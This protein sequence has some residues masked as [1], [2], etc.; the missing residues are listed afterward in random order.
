MTRHTISFHFR[1]LISRLPADRPSVRHSL[2]LFLIAF[3]LTAGPAAFG[4][5]L[6]G[7]VTDAATGQGVPFASIGVQGRPA[8]TQA[9]ENGHYR[10]SISRPADTLLVSA[11]GYRSAQ[12]AVTAPIL[13]I[14]LAP[15]PSVLGEVVVR[16]GENP[17]FRILRAVHQRRNTNDF[18]R[19][20]GYEYESYNQ[21]SIRMTDLDERFSRRRP[22][23][24]LLES[25]RAENGGRLPS[26]LPVFISESVSRIYSRRNPARRKEEILK[27]NINSIGITD[28]S[29][30]ALFT[31]AGFNTL[32]FYDNSVAVFRK[33]FI[34]PL[35][36]GGRLAYRYFVAD[37]VLQGDH[38]CYE[39]DFDPIND[40]DLVF[41]GKMWIDTVSYA[42]VQI[43]ARIG[44]SANINYIDRI[45]LSQ[46][47]GPVSGPGPAWIPQETR[48][49]IG[50]GEVVP[51][52]FRATVD[53][54]GLTREPV[55][56]RPRPVGFFDLEVNLA[57]DRNEVPPGYWS[58]LRQAAPQSAALEQTQ[59]MLDTLRRL[60]A[61]KTYTRAAQFVMNGGYLPLTRGLD[62]GSVFSA[63][64][65]NPVEGHRFRM[66]VQ[67]NPQFS[68]HWQLSGYA[69]YGT[70]DH[71]WKNGLEIS[72]I[73]KQRPLTLFTFKHGY[74]LEQLGLRQEDLAGN[75]LL[76]LT[77]RFGAYRQG[78]YQRETAFTAQRDLN[79]DV[80]Q[81]AGVRFRSMNFLA[82]F[83]AASSPHPTAAGISLQ[84]TEYFLETR[85]A[86]GRLPNRR[87]TSQRVT[88][89][90]TDTAP[91]ITLRYTYGTATQKGGSALPYHK[92]QLQLDHVLR[93]GLMGRTLYTVRAGY[94]PSV[95]PYP[96]LEMHLGNQTPVY[97]RNAY[98]LMN[99]AE[100]VSDSYVSLAAEHKFEG[101]LTN[102]LPLIRRWG[103][104]S[105]VTGNVLF[106]HVSPQNRRNLTE[107]GVTGP[108]RMWGNQL[109]EKPYAE[110]GYGFEN[111]L[112]TVRIQAL[113]RLTYRAGP[114]VTPF[115]VKACFQLG[116]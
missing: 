11:L 42:L 100:F 7:R 18:Q 103:W 85:Y 30:I 55:V 69:A 78:Y 61:V 43:D 110:V 116:L 58:T 34:S 20:N 92:M 13:N 60:P 96:L 33:E 19:L 98:N 65:F 88:R 41:Q 39:I 84:N 38:P 73:P 112:K 45:D 79:A 50:V 89:R 24:T 97:N 62:A 106:G 28:D 90:P 12:V 17:A 91:V 37:T 67:T 86:P 115:A 52:T 1:F 3:L 25:I 82:P 46:T 76:R 108:A 16:A 26:E 93:W 35:A 54:T 104:R 113:H 56:G 102:R 8:G 23:R 40:R 15:T 2:L 27:T 32:N 29:F 53:F 114:G 74:D 68:R 44:A 5:T 111:V 57:D 31:G 48:L 70:K 99:Y 75:P 94:T 51:H 77:S 95:L 71:V 64:A 81:K 14:S 10:L 66:G 49:T 36:E 9:D 109:W 80:T 59:R 87:A 72:Y 83:G 22:V 21:L 63:W 47:F 6:T 4:Q 101:L 105:F 107:Q